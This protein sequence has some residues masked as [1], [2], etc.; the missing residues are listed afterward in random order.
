MIYTK[1]NF[2]DVI[3][4]EPSVFKDD[5]GYFFESFKKEEFQKN[6]DN[7]DFVLEFESRSQQNTLRGLHYQSSVA[8]QSKLVSV[9]FGKVLDI[10]VDIRKNSKTFGEYIT[11]ELS[12]ENNK[13]IYIPK[14]YAHGFLALSDIA[15][16]HYKLDRYY[17]PEYYTGVNIF[18]EELNIK[19]P[20]DK[21]DICISEKDLNLPSLKDAILF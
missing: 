17:A 9:S 19:L 13:Q 2:D 20:I 6:V 5:R 16:M 11:V 12:D 1:T 18:D 15:V 8:A 10:I 3:I 7:V 21:K 4:V 14:G